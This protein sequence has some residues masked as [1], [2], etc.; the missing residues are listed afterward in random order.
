MLF[1]SPSLRV[2]ELVIVEADRGK[3]LGKIVN[4]T[5][6]AA[7]V[8]AF[9]RQQAAQAAVQAQMYGGGGGGPT[10]P[11]SAVPPGPASAAAPPPPHGKKEI[12]P[13]KIYARATAQDAQLLVAKHSDEAKAL[14]LCQSK[15]KQKKLPMEVIDAEYQW[16]VFS[17]FLKVTLSVM[18]RC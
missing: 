3:D 15:V 5:I 6:T 14:A 1:R 8:E 18:I 12:N 10:S 4:D 13:K 16:Y 7:E 11:D 2:G 9:Q 17:L